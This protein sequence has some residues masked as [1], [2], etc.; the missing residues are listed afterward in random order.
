MR[1]VWLLTDYGTDDPWVGVVKAVIERTAPGARVFDLTH[2]IPGGDIASGALRLA[3]CAP[4]L[5]KESVAMAVVDPGVGGPR[6]AV[7]VATLDGPILVGPDNGLLDGA[8]S[9][10]GGVASAVEVSASSWLPAEPS[11]TFHGR[12]V[13]APVTARLAS[14]EPLQEAGGPLDPA[15]LTVLPAPAATIED[16]LVEATVAVV[17][18]YGNL[19]LAASAADCRDLLAH[20]RE[21]VVAAAGRSHA[22]S[23][24]RT[25]GGVPAGRA[26]VHEDADG[27]LA[28]A[29][30]GG[31]AA[32]LLGAAVGTGVTVKWGS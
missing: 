9:R 2:S 24:A 1:T 18:R 17:D 29:V 11:A 25:F 5:P 22:A 16:G 19:S 32:A 26:L 8:V 15:S 30:N 14:G 31:N 10:L 21:V 3:D 6:R 4:W 28:I 23:V 20:D 13:F 12:D 27:R 7:A